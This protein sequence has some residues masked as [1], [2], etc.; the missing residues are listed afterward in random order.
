M[1][2]DEVKRLA[3]HERKVMAET[4]I[5][6]A[7]IRIDELK[8]QIVDEEERIKKAKENLAEANAYLKSIG[9]DIE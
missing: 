8:G 3:T 5:R 1:D 4:A 2:A 7:E 6:N 9:E